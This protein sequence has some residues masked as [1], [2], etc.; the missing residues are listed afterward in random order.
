MKMFSFIQK[1]SIIEVEKEQLLSSNFSASAI[2]YSTS[3]LVK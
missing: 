1:K 2:E 3:L